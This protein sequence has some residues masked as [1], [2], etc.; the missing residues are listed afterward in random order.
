MALGLIRLSLLFIFTGCGGG[1]LRTVTPTT[2][3]LTSEVQGELLK[4][5]IAGTIS[6]GVDT[7]TPINEDTTELNFESRKSFTQI[8]VSGQMGVSSRIDIFTK[9]GTHAPIMYGVKWQMLGHP[10]KEARKDS[11][12]FSVYMSGGRNRYQSQWESNFPSEGFFKANR[13]RTL[14]DYGF[15]Y[16]CRVLENILVYSRYSIIIDETHGKF[17]YEKNENLDQ[18]KFDLEGQHRSVALGGMWHSSKINIG[19]E[20][21]QLSTDWKNASNTVSDSLFLLLSK[22]FY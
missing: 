19:V 18:T 17:D 16:G 6:E 3:I 10:K 11:N 20:Y 22:N 13:I 4:T 7:S 21:S 5:Y 2:N 14:I 12:S 15:L 9:I 1:L 8:A